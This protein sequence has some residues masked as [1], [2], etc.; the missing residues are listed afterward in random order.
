MKIEE[1]NSLND[2]EL[3]M[4][5]YIVNKLENPPFKA[6]EVDAELFIYIQHQKLV[7]RIRKSED[8]IK[9]EYKHIYSSLKAKLRIN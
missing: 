2:D 8:K 7:D 4:L 1:L 6:H 9:E 5:W 3:A